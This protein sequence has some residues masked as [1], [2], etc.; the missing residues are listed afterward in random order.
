MAK[1]RENQST[2]GHT[3]KKKKTQTIDQNREQTVTIPREKKSSFSCVML[4]YS[5]V[6]VSGVVVA[7]VLPELAGYHFKQSY[8]Q[9]YGVLVE[10]RFRKSVD[11]LVEFASVLGPYVRETIG[12]ILPT[13]SED[14]DQNKQ[15][16]KTTTTTTSR[17]Q[18]VT[19]KK[20]TS[21][22]VESTTPATTTIKPI[23]N[24]KKILPH[25]VIYGALKSSDFSA[26]VPCV[27]KKEMA[28]VSSDKQLPPTANAQTSTIVN[29]S[30]SLTIKSSTVKSDTKGESSTTATQA[31]SKSTE[32]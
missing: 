15:S 29:P 23:S 13:K 9:K 6:F 3:E 25:R 17:P 18:T 1:N 19:S 27:R 24:Q 20:T 32:L 22:T 30:P 8:G 11:H 16:K 7:T 4:I 5:L 12:N 28:P 2:T 31:V 21:A 10:E 26:G 14:V